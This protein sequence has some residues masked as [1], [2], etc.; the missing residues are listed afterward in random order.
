MIKITK[1]FIIIKYIILGY[2]N[3]FLDIIRVITPE[4]KELYN[5]RLKK[6]QNCNFFDGKYCIL[7][8]CFIKA[9]VRVDYDLD[10]D[11]KSL[12]GCPKRYW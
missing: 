9:K 8:G 3:L 10:T 7:C 11:N 12:G 2:F 5:N 1:L 4:Q 6:C